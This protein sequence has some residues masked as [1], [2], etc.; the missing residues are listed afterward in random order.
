MSFDWE[1]LL[2]LAEYMAQEV[3]QFP[4]EEACCRSVASRAYYAVF[5]RACNYVRDVDSVEIYGHQEVQDH[6]KRNSARRDRLRIGNQLAQLH[7][8]RKRAD[9][10]DDLGE[11]PINTAS[12]A[13]AQ[14]KKIN[15]GIAKLPA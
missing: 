6:L 9:Y 13:L 2:E 7:Q 14:A 8:I 10:D 4:N 12:K 5:C 3:V 11:P 1:H 15:E